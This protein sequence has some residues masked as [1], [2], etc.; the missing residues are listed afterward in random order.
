M[1][2]LRARAPFFGFFFALTAFGNAQV[3]W[4]ESVNGDLSGDR[5]NPTNL[6]LGFGS[7][8]IIG[9][10][11]AGDREYVHFTIPSHLDLGR[12]VVVAYDSQDPVSFIGVQ[13]GSVF[14]E[15]HD[16]ANPANLL[17]WTLWGTDHIG[18]DILPAIGTGPG[19]PGFV[20][21]LTG[22]HYTFWIQQTGDL[23]AYT[24][25]FQAVPEP[26]TLAALGLGAAALLR[27]RRRSR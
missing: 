10:M 27:K 17:G 19:S 13:E 24:L 20:P 16:T 14:T 26:T 1:I 21:P 4:D 11:Q 22:D 9:T 6:T 3:I 25:D 23:T 18:T 15:P 12:I 2:L 7:N 8:R 5:L